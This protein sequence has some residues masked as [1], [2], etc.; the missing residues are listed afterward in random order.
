[1]LRFLAPSKV[2]AAAIGSI[3]L[4]L[5]GA[6][7]AD[8]SSWVYAGF[9]PGYLKN[10]SDDRFRYSLQLE[11]GLGTPPAALVFGMMGR[12]HSFFGDGADL[13]LLF[14]GATRGFVQGGYGLAVDAGAYQRFWGEGS[15][16][17]LASL[18]IGMPWGI[19]A[20]LGGG[21]G[22]NE[23]RFMTATLGLDFARLTVY[24]SYGTHWLSNPFLTDE[25]GRGAAPRSRD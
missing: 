2:L 19:T 14:R 1:V 16:G 6:A 13:A 17:G 25:R 8:V 3:G 24:R 20:S 12:L 10:A 23:Q 7:H 21:Y 18:V 9:G 4:F 15:Q 5:S 11:T 22:T